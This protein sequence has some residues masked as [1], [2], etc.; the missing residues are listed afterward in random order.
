MRNIFMS[1]VAVALLGL[2]ACNGEN[3][4][5]TDGAVENNQSVVPQSALPSE[6]APTLGDAQSSQATTPTTTQ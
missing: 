3:P 4:N 5:Q 1:A 2:A 6:T